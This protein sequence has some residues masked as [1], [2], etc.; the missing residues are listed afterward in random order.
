MLANVWS[1][2]NPNAYWPLYR[3]YVALSGTRELAVVQTRYLQNAAYMRL[4][5]V[6]VTYNLPKPWVSKLGI[7][8]AKVFFTG[9]NLLTIT[10]LHKWAQNY[11]PEV[12]NG[13]DPEVNPAGNIGNGYLYPMLK[14]YT[15]GINLTL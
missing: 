6:N 15:L 2:T 1:P 10:P 5:N 13:S 4:K 11:D 3:G 14:S 9:Q 8:G 7:T 12:I